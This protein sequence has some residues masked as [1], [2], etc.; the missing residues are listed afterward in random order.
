M[1]TP[2][3]LNEYQHEALSTASHANQFAIINSALSIAGE[4]NE[5]ADKVKKILCD[6][7]IVHKAD[8]GAIMFNP[9]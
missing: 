8:T 7:Q 4:A 6:T 1:K 5:C 3:T 2:M 9:E